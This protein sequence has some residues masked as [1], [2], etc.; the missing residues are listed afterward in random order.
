MQDRKSVK[1]LKGQVTVK[2]D[3]MDLIVRVY[4]HIDAKRPYLTTSQVK[5]F[6]ITQAQAEKALSENGGDL[7]RTLR[8]LVAS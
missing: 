5:E 8:A 7:D 3:D 4:R 2:K 6:D 1:S